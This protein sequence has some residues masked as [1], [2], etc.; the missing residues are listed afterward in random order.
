M[1]AV[2]LLLLGACGPGTWTLAV[3]GG[4]VDGLTD[5][6]GCEVFVTQWTLTVSASLVQVDD[7]VVSATGLM[8]LDVA[9]AGTIRLPEVEVAP[10]RF[11]AV[12]L[13]SGAPTEG[14]AVASPLPDAGAPARMVVAGA[15]LEVAGRLVCEDVDVGFSWLLPGPIDQRCRW[16]WAE[17]ARGDDRTVG[18]TVT[19]QAIFGGRIASLAAADRD[20]DGDVTAAELASTDPVDVGLAEGAS[21]LAEVLGTAS[22]ASLLMPDGACRGGTMGQ[23]SDG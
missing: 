3:D 23:P 17:V 20:G 18:V 1:R 7:E 12:W 4:A 9:D 8:V 14:A 15:G 19:P 6:D 11:D 10:G 16:P 21:T 13:R 2:T 22:E 5:A